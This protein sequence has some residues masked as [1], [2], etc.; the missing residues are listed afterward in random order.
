MAENLRSAP[1]AE[2]PTLWEILQGTATATGRDFFDALVKHL[3][4]ALGCKCAW[5]TEWIEDGKRLR[6]LSFWVDGRYVADYEY[7]IVG[8]PCESVI[9]GC[10]LIVVPDRVVQLFPNDPDLPPLDAVSYMGQPLLDADGSI[11][12]NLAVLDDGPVF[13]GTV[14]SLEVFEDA[15]GRDRGRG[16]PRARRRPRPP[17]RPPARRRRS[18]SST[19]PRDR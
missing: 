3:A 1:A 7:A 15:G 6:A 5:V 18:R 10:E 16:P 8:T 9:G 19:A 2:Y 17:P 11:L 13:L 12:G 14:E 4:R